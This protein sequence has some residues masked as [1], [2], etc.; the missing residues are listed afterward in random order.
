M[1]RNSRRE[2]D[3]KRRPVRREVSVK[4]DPRKQLEEEEQYSH[5][6]TYRVS[7]ETGQRQRNYDIR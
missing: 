1:P 5:T 7:L 4:G 6:R 2:G 3:E